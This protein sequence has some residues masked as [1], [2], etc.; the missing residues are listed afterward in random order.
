MTRLDPMWRIPKRFTLQNEVHK[1]SH[2]AINTYMLG[3]AQAQ[4]DGS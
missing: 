4:D 3:T 2:N 1:R